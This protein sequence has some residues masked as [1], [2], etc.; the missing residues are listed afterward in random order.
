MSGDLAPGGGGVYRSQDR[1]V[2]WEWFSKGLPEG[3]PLF[4]NE[5][6]Q[7]D[8]RQLA[9]SPDGSA[10]LRAMDGRRLYRLDRVADAWREMPSRVRGRLPFPD[11]H[12]PGR[13]ILCGAAMFETL[14]GGAT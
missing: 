3:P 7:G 1:G 14:D 10:I 5:E 6:W 9:F 2:S 8:N 13:F 12:V 4:T 11:P